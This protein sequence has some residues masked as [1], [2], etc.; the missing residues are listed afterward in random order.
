M[1]A[2]VVEE[3]EYTDEETASMAGRFVGVVRLRRQGYV[4][5]NGRILL[6]EGWGA[7]NSNRCGR[8]SCRSARSHRISCFLGRSHVRKHVLREKRHHRQSVFE[9]RWRGDLVGIVGAE[10]EDETSGEI[11]ERMVS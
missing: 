4:D 11:G 9:L 6:A 5:W 1:A 8:T 2:V 7:G 3:E 10:E